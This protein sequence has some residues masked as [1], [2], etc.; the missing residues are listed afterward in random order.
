MQI[1]LTDGT[2]L[3]LRPIRPEDKLLLAEALRRLSAES[4][5]KRFLSPKP[6]LS[7]AE[8]RYL[9]EVDGE[10]HVALVA[11]DPADG[12]LVAVAR[13]VRLE[14]DPATAE[15]AIVVGDRLQGRGLGRLLALRLADE[16][17]RHGITRFHA[18]FLGE[19][20]PAKRLMAAIAERLGSGRAGSGTV[21]LVAELAA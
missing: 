18:T 7:A 6:R 14:D 5:H 4:V 11:V 9:T 8:L 13:Y 17:R 15:A 19:N 2:P 12:R 21:E 1:E 20:V 10:S 16:A 3:L